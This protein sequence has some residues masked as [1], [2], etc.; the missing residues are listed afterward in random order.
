[1]TKGIV[2]LAQN[3]DETDY[4]K[5]AYL[6]ALSII[7]TNPN[8]KVSLI[9]NDPVDKNYKNIY[10]KIFFPIA[11]TMFKNIWMGYIW[12]TNFK[13]DKLDCLYQGD[14]NTSASE[15]KN[16]CA[17]NFYVS[18]YN[19]SEINSSNIKCINNNKCIE[20]LFEKNNSIS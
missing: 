3:T 12:D 20:Q 2:M 15:R 14:A 16:R 8:T 19:G 5:Q 4:V 1:M 10:D 11:G 17:Y 13:I 6:N 9:T 18:S 7:H